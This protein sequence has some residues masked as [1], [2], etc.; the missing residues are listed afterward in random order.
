ML[1]TKPLRDFSLKNGTNTGQSFSLHDALRD[2][3]KEKKIVL[4]K[5]TPYIDYVPPKLTEGKVWFISYYVKN[6]AT[7]KLRRVR[8]KVNRIRSVRERRKAAKVMMASLAEKLAL[9]WNPFITEA[10]PRAGT[11]LFDALD[12]FLAVKE[13]EMEGQSIRTYRSFVRVFR[14]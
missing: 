13:K 9:G 6:P 1:K 10:A 2:L 12:T 14:T 7:G 8:V 4:F 5:P 11:P 3:C